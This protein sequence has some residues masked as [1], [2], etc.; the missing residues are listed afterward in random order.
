[1]RGFDPGDDDDDDDHTHHLQEVDI[2]GDG[3][4]NYEE[5]VTALFKVQKIVKK[6]GRV[7]QLFFSGV[8]LNVKEPSIKRGK[9]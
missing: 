2:D 7:C 5:F 3:A 1:M 8:L 9:V 6:G 4:V